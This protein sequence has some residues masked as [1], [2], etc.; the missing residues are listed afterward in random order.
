MSNQG[1]GWH[2]KAPNSNFNLGGG[3]VPASLNIFNKNI[4]S[5]RD[6]F[7]DYIQFEILI[8]SETCNPIC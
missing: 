1:M 4:F 2:K 5:K 7:P 6:L 3:G 8:K